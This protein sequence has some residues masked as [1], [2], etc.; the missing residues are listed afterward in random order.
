MPCVVAKIVRRLKD[1]RGLL[2]IFIIIMH[3]Y[4]RGY[5]CSGHDALIVATCPMLIFTFVEES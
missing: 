1:L 5:L 2:T 4:L 3:S